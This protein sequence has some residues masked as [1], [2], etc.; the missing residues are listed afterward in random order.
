M[1][2]LVN[3]KIRLQ[4]FECYMNVLHLDKL[5]VL[6]ALMAR[7]PLLLTTVTQ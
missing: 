4:S 5:Q 7:V 3:L 1:N 2:S 6:C